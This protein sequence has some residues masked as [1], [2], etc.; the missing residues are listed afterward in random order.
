LLWGPY[1]WADG[2]TPRKQD[3][4]IWKREDLREDGTHPSITSGREKVAQ[5]LLAFL[6]TDPTARLWFVGPKP[7]N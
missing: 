7:A 6:K 1:L 4:L 3:G 5:L 2:L